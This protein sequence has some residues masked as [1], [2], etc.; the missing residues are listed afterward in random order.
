MRNA[1]ILCAVLVSFTGCAQLVAPQ[2]GYAYPYP[3]AY[4]YDSWQPSGDRFG[5]RF[6]HF[7]HR[8]FG[9]GF[10]HR[11]HAEFHHHGG[12]GSHHGNDH[13]H[14]GTHH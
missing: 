1:A 6:H 4:S 2:A 7:H 9:G 11:P 13:G 10:A 8:G 12:A 5:G 14:H 3:Y